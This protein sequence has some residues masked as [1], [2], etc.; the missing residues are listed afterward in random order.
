MTIDPTARP[1]PAS[2]NLKLGVTDWL[3]S[4][5][6]LGRARGGSPSSLGELLEAC[7]AYLLL[8]AKEELADDVRAKIAPSD[9]VQVTLHEACKDF[10][11]FRGESEGELL[12]WLRRILINNARDAIRSFREIAKRELNREISL[13]DAGSQHGLKHKLVS[14]QPS[15]SGQAMAAERWRR[16]LQA[17]EKLDEKP[18]QV[19][20][21]RNLEQLSFVEIGRRLNISED[22]ARKIWSRA[23]QR[24]AITL[25]ESDDATG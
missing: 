19:L 11:R 10:D 5:R 3:A 16:V 24:L 22:G 23:V 9:L 17:L 7:R 18:R 14:T 6:L 13:D 12:A 2:H 4:S 15:P 8:M 21:W 25:R 1:E 20:R